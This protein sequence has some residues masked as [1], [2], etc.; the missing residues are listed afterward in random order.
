MRQILEEKLARF[1]ELEKQLLDPEVQASSARMSAAARE[2]GSL[3]KVAT[4]Y[5]R[6]RQLNQ[7]IVE[8]VEMVGGG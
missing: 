1:E 8:T 7:Q 2:H 6:F 3:A 4:K 5:R